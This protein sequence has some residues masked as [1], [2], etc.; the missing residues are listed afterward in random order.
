MTSSSNEKMKGGKSLAKDPICGMYVNEKTAKHKSEYEGKQY[1]F[2]K[3]MCKQRFD[4]NP[5]RFAK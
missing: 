3:A 5:A 4:E 1:Y 2:C